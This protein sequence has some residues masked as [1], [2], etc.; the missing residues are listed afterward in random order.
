MKRV[1]MH[2]KGRSRWA[3]MSP[4]A[5]TLALALAPAPLRA[6]ADGPQP[7]S[8]MVQYL[9]SG[10]T[11]I[12]TPLGVAIDPRAGEVIL[13]NTGARRVEIYDLSLRPRASFAHLVPGPGGDLVEGKPKYLAVDATGRLFISDIHAAYVD[14]C[15]F[16]GRSVGR[17][18]LP[19][20]DDDLASGGAGPIAI[21][22]D[23]RIFVASRGERAKVYVFGPDLKLQTSWGESGSAPGQ[24]KAV[25][26]IAIGPKGEV[27]VACVQTEKVVQLFD[28]QGKYLRGIGVH[29]IGLGNFSQP[30]GVAVTPDGRIWV[31]DS[32]R[33]NLQ[34]FDPAGTVLG[35]VDGGNGPGAWLYPSALA[36]DGNGWFAIAEMGGSRLRLLHIP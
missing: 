15:D 6:D 26:A 5:G 30:T 21:A 7:D 4:V 16:R 10:G 14:V 2:H 31:V 34:V 35:G 12:E 27:V 18:D 36:T 25:T 13:A 3:L 29:D 20:P 11:H 33:A 8:S 19:A 23:G 28:A 22:P 1:A 17:I 24:L 9:G 32:I